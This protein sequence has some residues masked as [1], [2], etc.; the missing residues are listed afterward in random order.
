MLGEKQLKELHDVEWSM[1]GTGVPRGAPE[2]LHT[3]APL[4]LQHAAKSL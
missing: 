4:A 3:H 1:R 2:Y